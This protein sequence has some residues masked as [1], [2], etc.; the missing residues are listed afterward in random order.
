MG[1]EKKIIH[2]Y[3][4]SSFLSEASEIFNIEIS[5]EVIEEARA[6][7]D[8]A[9]LYSKKKLV[10]PRKSKAATLKISTAYDK[11]ERKHW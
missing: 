11:A 9:D 8:T 3:S 6:T 10:H 1:S 7:P 2:M 4:V 5:E